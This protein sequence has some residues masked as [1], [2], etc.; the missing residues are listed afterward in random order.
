MCE[1]G[2]PNS[3]FDFSSQRCL[4]LLSPVAVAHCLPRSPGAFVERRYRAGPINFD[5]YTTPLRATKAGRNSGNK[6]RHPWVL[7][8]TSFTRGR[9]QAPTGRH[10]NPT[11]VGGSDDEATVAAWRR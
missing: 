3:P 10:A 2:A 4:S 9:R 1:A 11:L 7:P 8:G 6:M 5:S